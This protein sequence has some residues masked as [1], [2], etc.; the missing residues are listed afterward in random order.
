MKVMETKTLNQM[1]GSEIHRIVASVFEV[2]EKAQFEPQVD[3]KLQSVE[4][5]EEGK[6]EK[7]MILFQKKNSNIDELNMIRK[8]LG[9]NF[10]INLYA[11]KDVM[12]I[13][14]EASCTDFI[15]LLQRKGSHSSTLFN[16]QGDE[17][18]Q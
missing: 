14:I 3:A 11:K 9:N 16:N 12:Q 15:T 1:K 13:S 4:K 17:N 5:P 18:K 2:I 6:P 10:A 7:W 8:E